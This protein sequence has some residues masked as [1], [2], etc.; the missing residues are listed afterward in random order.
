MSKVFNVNGACRPD[1][2]YMIDLK[3]RLEKIKRMVDN[4]NYFTIN[5]ARQYGKTT[6]L[7][8]L[9]DFLKT[10]YE[11]ISLDFQRISS[12]SFE[13]EPL[14]VSAISEELLDSVQRF[15]EGIAEKLTAFAEGTARLNSL[16][17]LFRVF[18]LWCGQSRKQIVLIIDEI[19]TATNN[20]VF[21]DF[22]AQRSEERRVGKECRL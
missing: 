6:T 22:L 1:M 5:K 7:R 14:F 16:Q 8:A 9:A 17:A 12:L 3:P 18:R 11:T 13:S 20:Q 2:H 19:D 21:L 10:E 4:G 15:P